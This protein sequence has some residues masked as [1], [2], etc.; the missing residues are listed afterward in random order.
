[1]KRVQLTFPNPADVWNFLVVTKI[2][3]VEVAN[4]T[5]SGLFTQPQLDIACTNFKAAVR[6]VPTTGLEGVQEV[7]LTGKSGTIY[8]GTIYGKS[9]RPKSQPPSAIVCLSNSS[10]TNGSWQHK[11]INVYHTD[12]VAKELERFRERADLSRMI[13]IDD[14]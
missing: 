13:V 4:A 2:A 5:M 8:K 12:A 9:Q 10:F 1:M 11:I 3:N 14:S 6:E 7:E